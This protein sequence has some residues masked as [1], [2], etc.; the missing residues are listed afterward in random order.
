[1][2]A[3]AKRYP[4]V[5]FD[6]RAADDD[7]EKQRGIVRDFVTQGYHVIIVSPKESGALA[8]PCKEA[9]AREIEVIVLDRELGT[10]DYTCFV[11][12]D[13]LAIGRAAGQEIARLL[14]AGGAIV[15]IQ[16][17]MTSSPAQE[18][19]RGFVEALGLGDRAGR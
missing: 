13:N 7:T 12:G 9:L 2:L 4:Q 1:M 5:Q 19:H 6:Y 16:G 17:L 14:P 3:W 11:G 18:R 10:D 8:E 15:E